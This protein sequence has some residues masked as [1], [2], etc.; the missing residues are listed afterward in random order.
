[1]TAQDGSNEAQQNLRKS[2]PSSP[3]PPI[4]VADVALITTT[5]STDLIAVIKEVSD[6][7]RTSKTHELIGDIV[8][9]DTT[10]GASDKVAVIDVSVFGAP[11]IEQLKGAIG[12]PMAFFN[13]SIACDKKG[14]KQKIT[15][16]G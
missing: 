12:T 8:L 6:K 5:C 9:V 16:Y 1:M 10:V 2:M 4:S 3:E 14:D 13:L 7:T 15:H 11:K